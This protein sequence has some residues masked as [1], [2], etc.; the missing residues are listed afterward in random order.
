MT[1]P[2]G[3]TAFSEHRGAMTVAAGGTTVRNRA[4]G[5]YLSWIVAGRPLT[6]AAR[7]G[8]AANQMLAGRL[9]APVRAWAPTLRCRARRVGT[10]A[11]QLSPGLKEP[12]HKAHHRLSR[13]D[14]AQRWDAASAGTCQHP[15]VRWAQHTRSYRLPGRSLRL[16]A[17]AT[18]SK[19]AT[20]ACGVATTRRLHRA[21]GDKGDSPGADTPFSAAL[22][23]PGKFHA[24][25]KRYGPVALGKT[26][27]VVCCATAL[28]LTLA[29]W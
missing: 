17:A 10:S 25:V 8:N 24:F 6:L 15:L 11:L 26:H 18:A 20:P 23:S 27:A 1:T 4:S 12:G 16:W 14:G 22:L 9:P 2:S 29:V 7:R 21:S 5:A 3:H 13:W 19:P 28:H